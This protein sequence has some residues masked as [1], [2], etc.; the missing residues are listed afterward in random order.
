MTNSIINVKVS[1]LNPGMTYRFGVI[2]SPSTD[3]E[4]VGEVI[5]TTIPMAPI[6]V[7]HERYENG[8]KVVYGEPDEGQCP[9]LKVYSSPGPE[10]ESFRVQTHVY[11]F[12][13]EIF[14]PDVP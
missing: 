5:Q 9:T 7:S 3:A 13:E 6:L 8:V 12:G 4:F 1:G 11:H 10:R 2:K 14:L